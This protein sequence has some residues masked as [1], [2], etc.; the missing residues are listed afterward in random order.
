V[1]SWS[2]C[3][4]ST[5]TWQHACS[6][7]RGS[8]ANITGVLPLQCRAAGRAASQQFITCCQHLL[9]Q[10]VST[11]HNG[12]AQQVWCQR[13]VGLRGL[14]R[15]CA[16][17]SAPAAC[18]VCSCQR[19]LQNGSGR[20]AAQQVR[21]AELHLKLLE[22]YEC[23]LLHAVKFTACP[24]ALQEQICCSCLKSGLSLKP[25]SKHV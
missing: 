18:V 14:S 20:A 24:A 5:L 23:L 1:L 13:R 12:T 22:D 10:M 8:W 2:C 6:W 19:Q 7:L 15:L 17:R 16:A 4:G 11:V 3:A 21:H 9:L 25:A